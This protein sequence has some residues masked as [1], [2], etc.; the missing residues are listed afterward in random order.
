MDGVEG[1]EAEVDEV[2]RDNHLIWGFFRL[3]IECILVLGPMKVPF[4]DPNKDCDQASSQFQNH[5]LVE[6][7]RSADITHR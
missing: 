4:S 1:V 5:D 3:Y 7:C 2:E 6:H